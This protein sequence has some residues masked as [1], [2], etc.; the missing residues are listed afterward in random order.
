MCNPIVPRPVQRPDRSIK[1]AAK[2]GWLVG[3]LAALPIQAVCQTGLD[4]AETAVRQIQNG[5]LRSAAVTVRQALDAD[6]GDLLLHN[7]AASLLM[8]TG[9]TNGALTE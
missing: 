3:I 1:A 6:P 2:I 5:D 4:R 8:A 9:D 7:L